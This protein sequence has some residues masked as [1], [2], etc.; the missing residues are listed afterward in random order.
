MTLSGMF[1]SLK[2]CGYVLD[3]KTDE[4]GMEHGNNGQFVSR[5][6]QS[7][8]DLQPRESMAE[9]KKN[10]AKA[11]KLKS[12]NIDK[13]RNM[14]DKTDIENY[15]NSISPIQNKTDK[16]VAVF[17]KNT[18]GKI[19]YH[20]GFPI[21]QTI[22]SLPTLFESAQFIYSEPEKEMEGHKYHSNTECYKNYLNKIEYKGTE[23]FIR[24]TT[25]EE[26]VVKK[27]KATKRNDEVHSIAISDIEITKARQPYQ[28]EQTSAESAEN[29]PFID[30]RLQQLKEKINEKQTQDRSLSDLWQMINR[31]KY[32]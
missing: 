27:H 31:D 28:T 2:Q 29:K 25:R 16:N 32:I 9:I 15:F 11:E 26:K 7:E 12:T 20:K 1:D 22:E 17:P 23:Y 10:L 3:N 30:K 5:G 6:G 8:N 19:H 18:A 4:N 21:G 13:N 24:F 14:T